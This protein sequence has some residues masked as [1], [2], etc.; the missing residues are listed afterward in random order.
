MKISTF[1]TFV[2]V[3]SVS[4]SV[5]SQNTKFTLDTQNK[6]VR[7]VLKSI[8]A[9]SNFRFFY[10]DGFIGLNKTVDLQIE[11]ML[12]EEILDK[13]IADSE[14]SY[15]V[16]END[17]IVFTPK[18]MYQQQTV[19]GKVTDA[20]TGEPLPGVY[21]RIDGTNAG[22]ITDAEGNYSLE[23][24][25]P[26]AVLVFSF[27]GYNTENVTVAG[28]SVINILLVADLTELEEVVVIGY[29]TQKRADVTSSVASVKS[30]SFVK[31]SV[32]DAGQLIQGKVSGLTVIYPTGDPTGRTQFL[33]RG[34]TSLMGKNQD[35]L[36]LID[37]VPGDMKTVPPQDIESV[38][39]LKDGS[40]AA[41][42]GT[43]GTNGVIIITTKRAGANKSSVEYSSYVSTQTVARKL[44]LSTA[45]QFRSQLASG[46][47]AVVSGGITTYPMDDNGASTDWVKEISQT[48]LSHN[49]N[50]TIRN[51]NERS[52]FMVNLNYNNNQGRFK[53]SYNKGLSGHIDFNQNMFDDKVKINI[54][55]YNSS[56]NWW[57]FPTGSYYQALKQN[58]TSPLKNEDGTW[59]EEV[60]KFEYSNP[61][62]MLEE[63]DGK[64]NNQIGRYKGAIT[65]T[66][67]NG[68]KLSGV[69]SYARNI[70]KKGYF[71]TKQHIS[72]LRDNRNGYANIEGREWIDRLAELTA[73][74]AK[75]I[76]K[77]N[78]MILGGYSYQDNKDDSYFMENWNFQ[79]DDFG[80]DNID[81][82][83]A[84]VLGDVAD[85]VRSARSET[86]LIG[87]FG[88]LTYNFSD[89]YLLMASIRREE[90]SQLWGTKNPWGTFPAVSVGWR[91]T[92]ESFMSNQNLFDDIKLRAGYGVTGSQPSDLFRGVGLLGF[93]YGNIY[94]NGKWIKSMVPS[95]NANPDLKW[96][97]KHELDIGLDFSMLNKRVS[98]SIDYYNRK[99]KN[100][101][102]LYDV[103]SP[104]NLFDRTLAN[105]GDMENKGLEVLVNIVPV[106]KADF[107]WNTSISYSTNKN[108]L[109]SLS[110]DMYKLS[111]DYIQVGGVF[112]PISTFTH[113]LRVGGPIGDFYGYKVI[114]IGNDPTGDPANYGQ[115]VYEG[116]NGDPLKY[117]DCTHSFGDKKV[118][119]N[120]LPKFYLGWNNN[121]RYKN[122]DLSITQRG[123]FG[124]QVFNQQRMMFENPKMKQYNLLDNAFDKVY[125]K[126]QLQSTPEFNS[127]YVEDGDFWKVDNITLGYN[128]N[129]TGTKYIQSIRIYASVLNAFIITGYKGID[130]EV[131]LRNAES[132]V[133]SGV[134]QVR[135]SGL[136]PGSDSPYTYPTSR[137]FSLGLNV[138]F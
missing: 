65:Y 85:P 134:V 119:G 27:V 61:L 118:I 56:N 18:E 20:A 44:N 81:L 102:W 60:A 83:A 103:P 91:I 106:Q 14:M 114:D 31:G 38:D 63:S 96:E 15:K 9:Q 67:I 78:F 49:Q 59:F 77:H 1:L 137:I 133:Q 28:K 8:E 24:T 55:L 5:Y 136:D 25:S 12:V 19:T 39:V 82:G 101:L 35:P 84:V 107:E 45:S 135:T 95:Q 62:S 40:A 74:Y 105:V 4:A 21:I 132:S 13:L 32:V 123:A 30:E 70:Q 126:T 80:Y 138:T 7:D 98:G 52:N 76:G 46:D 130:P 111:T 116:A 112:P 97:E 124:F 72:T 93:T 29:G 120:G 41:I 37:G 48:A 2:F 121:F 87:F 113:L 109:V 33:L 110:N 127:Y 89:K 23:T 3:A 43:R 94:Y 122:L 88:R 117:T 68:L 22:T 71:E 11:D 79:T 75:S 17:L 86:N 36:I 51:G 108:K 73:E 57:G 6:T 53:H 64:Y 115:W 125:G 16:L 129:K 99:V 90:A 104:P 100:L 69:F 58:P 42:Y 128:M 47:R 34:N 50:L 26:N 66:P 54:N 10:N 131:S 92:K